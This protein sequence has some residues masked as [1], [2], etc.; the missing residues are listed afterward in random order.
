MPGAIVTAFV[1]PVAFLILDLAA[2]LRA[3]EGQVLLGLVVLT[4]FLLSILGANIYEFYEGRRGWPGP[5]KRWRT[6]RW[7]KH[8]TDRLA[9]AQ[10]PKALDYDERWSALR[11]FPTAKGVDGIV[12]PTAT[13]PT[14]LGNVLASYENYPEDRY[15]M[16][17]VFYWDRLWLSLDKDSRDEIDNA[18]APTD[19]L[20]YTSA[21]LLMSAVIYLGLAAVAAIATFL[22]VGS[23]DELAATY[24]ILGLVGVLGAG[25]FYSLSIPGHVSNGE[26]FKSV[27]DLYRSRVA[28]LG[29]ASSNERATW[30]RIS[31]ELQYSDYPQSAI[32]SG[33]ASEEL[34][35]GS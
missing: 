15:G 34:S 14:K 4:G 18:W 8:V 7:A 25:L 2:R 35:G 32:G 23:L 31:P 26:A 17:S 21:G 10:D 13:A 19:A 6:R 1:S 30:E 33:V 16:D 12:R 11:Q 28:T 22:R 29:A 3:Y 27:F 5:V 24:T 9:K 20:L